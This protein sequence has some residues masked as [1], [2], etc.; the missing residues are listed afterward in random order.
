MKVFDTFVYLRS[1]CPIG[2]NL[3]DF[4]LN[5]AIDSPNEGVK[6]MA[7]KLLDAEELFLPRDERT[8]R[9]LQNPRFRLVLTDLPDGVTGIVTDGD[10]DWHTNYSRPEH[11]DT[12][13]IRSLL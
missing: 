10:T 2:S 5:A 3:N 4:I 9:Q 11:L 12:V 6:D 8:L 13:Y 1:Q 7:R